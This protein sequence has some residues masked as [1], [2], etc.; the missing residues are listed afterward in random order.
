MKAVAQAI[1]PA[2]DVEARR[3]AARDLLVPSIVS[4]PST[5]SPW[6][7]TRNVVAPRDERCR[8][9]HPQGSAGDASAGGVGGTAGALMKSRRDPARPDTLAL[10]S[11]RARSSEPGSRT[12]GHGGPFVALS[13]CSLGHLNR[14]PARTGI[15]IARL[16]FCTNHARHAC[17]THHRR[18]A[19]DRRASRLPARSGI[20]RAAGDG[21]RS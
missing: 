11:G 12:V 3:P 21:M 20:P 7:L 16:A 15:A 13:R 4:A 9:R 10:S 18:L 8:G 14:Q 5:P 17:P 1:L 2:M 19:R 6:R